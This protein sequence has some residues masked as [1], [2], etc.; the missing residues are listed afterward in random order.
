MHGSKSGHVTFLADSPAQSDPP[1]VGLGSVQFL[2][3][4]LY[5][6]TPQSLLHPDSSSTQ[7][8]QQPFT[9]GKKEINKHVRAVPCLTLCLLFVFL[10]IP[11]FCA[12]ICWIIIGRCWDTSGCLT[13]VRSLVHQVYELYLVRNFITLARPQDLLSQAREQRSINKPDVIECSA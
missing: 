2:A 6:F 7:G 5:L 1:G 9:R 13:C 8:D 4:V 12:P 3:W 10:S 11:F